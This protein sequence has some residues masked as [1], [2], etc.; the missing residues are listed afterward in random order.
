MRY[1]FRKKF[2][3][4]CA[5]E[6]EGW[7]QADRHRWGTRDTGERERERNAHNRHIYKSIFRG[8]IVSDR[9]R[10]Y[11]VCMIF[12]NRLLRDRFSGVFSGRL[13]NYTVEEIHNNINNNSNNNKNMVFK[14]YLYVCVTIRRT[15]LRPTTIRPVDVITAAIVD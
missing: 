5:H 3:T 9:L 1:Y 2:A 12:T 14:I 6:V 7:K 4:P 13:A 15:G 10:I 11:L 8:C